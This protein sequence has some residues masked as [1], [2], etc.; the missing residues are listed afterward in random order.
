M[1]GVAPLS[2]SRRRSKAAEKQ[3]S[4]VART[5]SKQTREAAERKAAGLLNPI[6]HGA[7]QLRALGKL[8]THELSKAVEIK[9]ERKTHEHADGCPPLNVKNFD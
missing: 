1:D 7:E 5:A 3:A 9:V 6:A 2:S 8:E 4:A